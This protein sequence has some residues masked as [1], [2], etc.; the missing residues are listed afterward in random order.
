MWRGKGPS[1]P[2][3]RAPFKAPNEF[4]HGPFAHPLLDMGEAKIG[5]SP[6]YQTR[7]GEN[8]EVEGRRAVLGGLREENRPRDNQLVWPLRPFFHQVQER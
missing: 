8:S 1:G 7:H 4:G 2:R 6:V 5:P 3:R